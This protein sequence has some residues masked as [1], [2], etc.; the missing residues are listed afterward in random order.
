MRAHAHTQRVVA[1]ISLAAGVASGLY[2]LNSQYSSVSLTSS[3]TGAASE[4]SVLAALDREAANTTAKHW[5]GGSSTQAHRDAR[6]DAN[7]RRT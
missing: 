5:F 1:L 3:G 6:G 4:D 7:A 2:L